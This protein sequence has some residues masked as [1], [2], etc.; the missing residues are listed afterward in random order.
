MAR[1]TKDTTIG[2]VIQIDAGVIPILMGAGMHC[3]GCPSSAGETLEEA[4]MVHG[5]D[6]DMLVEEIQSYLQS[7]G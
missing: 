4:A 2:E 7:L 5:I 6:S 1:V 3:V